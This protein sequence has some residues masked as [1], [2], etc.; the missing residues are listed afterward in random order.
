MVA[1]SDTLGRQAAGGLDRRAAR[2]GRE[3]SVTILLIYK[4]LW[5]DPG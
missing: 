4:V 1:V 3:P 5:P 2:L